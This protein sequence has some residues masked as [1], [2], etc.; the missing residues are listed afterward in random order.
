MKEIYNEINNES[1]MNGLTTL[2][3][4]L[5]NNEDENNRIKASLNEN[6]ECLKPKKKLKKMLK[7]YYLSKDLYLSSSMISTKLNI[8]IIFKKLTRIKLL[9]KITILI[10]LE[11]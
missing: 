1:S 10:I 3:E 7:K 2:F 11:K 6:T 5:N 4:N 9:L 8:R